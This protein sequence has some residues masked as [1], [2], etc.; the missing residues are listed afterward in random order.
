MAKISVS[1]AK[2]IN[3]KVS[4]NVTSSTIIK[5]TDGLDFFKKKRNDIETQ[6]KGCVPKVGFQNNVLCSYH[7]Q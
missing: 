4:E 6:I 7:D 5:S 3:R 1:I 2:Q